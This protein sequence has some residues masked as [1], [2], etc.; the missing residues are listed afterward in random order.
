MQPVQPARQHPQPQC[1]VE[2]EIPAFPGNQTPVIDPTANNFT[3]RDHT[4]DK[5]YEVGLWA[6]ELRSNGNKTIS[7]P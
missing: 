7:E 6:R 4:A 1:H 5:P 2:E 3:D